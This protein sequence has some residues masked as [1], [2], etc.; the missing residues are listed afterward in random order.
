MHSIGTLRERSLHAAL[1]QW[2]AQPGD[3]FE[4]RVDGSIIDVVRG[5]LLIEIQTR[6]FTALKRKLGKL[7]VAHPVH[8]IYPIAREKWIV[9]LDSDGETVLSRRKSPKHGRAEQV[10]MELVNIPSLIH[11]P[12]F[13]LEVVFI[14]EEEVW[15][16]NST[17]RRSWRHKGWMRLDR[18]LIETLDQIKF[19]TAQDFRALLPAALSAQFTSR[20]VAQMLGVPRL[21]AQRMTYCLRQMGVIHVTGK[22]GRALLYEVTASAPL[23][24]CHP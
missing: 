10:F 7:I 14:R 16:A 4:V 13:S 21:L 17:G 22:R 1:K 9:K 12:N 15:S 19:Q 18:R 5:D 8:L 6:N 20:D 24:S 23:Q 11:H 2:Y 3:E